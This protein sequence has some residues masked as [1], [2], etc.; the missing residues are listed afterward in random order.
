MRFDVNAQTPDLHFCR[1]EAFPGVPQAGFEPAYTAPEYVALLNAQ[2]VKKNDL[3]NP[4]ATAAHA[5]TLG[6]ETPS[7]APA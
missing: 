6:W 1:S 3:L 2:D 5:K 7:R 4:C